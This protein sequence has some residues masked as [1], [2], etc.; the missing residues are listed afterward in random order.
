MIFE[1]FKFRYRYLS[2]FGRNNNKNI[3]AEA[4]RRQGQAQKHVKTKI[5]YFQIFTSKVAALENTFQLV[6]HT[7]QNWASLKLKCPLAK[8]EIK[9]IRFQIWELH[10]I[11]DLEKTIATVY[12]TP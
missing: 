10:F 2:R 1:I 8:I 5:L 6:Y 12:H 11:N 9:K 3:G 7:S 4:Q